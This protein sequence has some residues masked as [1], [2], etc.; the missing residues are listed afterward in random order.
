CA[1]FRELQ[2]PIWLPVDVS[3]NT[4]LY[5]VA[6]TYVV[7]GYLHAVC[8]HLSVD[9]LIQSYLLYCATQHRLIKFKQENIE[10]YFKKKTKR[11]S[12]ETT[13]EGLLQKKIYDQIIQCIKVY[14]A[15]FGYAGEMEDMYSFGI[16]S[17]LFVVSLIFSICAY[18]LTKATSFVDILYIL[19]FT[20]PMILSMFLYCYPGT[21]II[22]ESTSI[23]EAIFKSPWYTYDKR[24]KILL[25]TFVER[26]NKPI[27][28]TVG[29]LVDLSLETFV[30]IM[31]RSYSLI[32]VL[33]NFY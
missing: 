17:Q 14:D 21:L 19:S 10:K 33:Q 25:L 3:N 7:T 20:I 23:G 31:N 5:A 6:N 12:H 1:I 28:V 30:L 2:L 26:T 16:F 24:T 4:F 29:K 8:G 22:E 11:V 9:M 32:A 27:K 18:S 13:T 15:V